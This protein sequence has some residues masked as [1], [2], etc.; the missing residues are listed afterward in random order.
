MCIRAL[1]HS[2][3]CAVVRLCMH[4]RITLYVRALVRLCMHNCTHLCSCTFMHLCSCT[5]VPA[6]LRNRRPLCSHALVLAQLHTIMQLC[7]HAFAQTQI[8]ESTA[9]S[10]R[11]RYEPCCC[12]HES[13]ASRKPVP[14][15]CASSR[16]P[17][18]ERSR[19]QS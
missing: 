7:V 11:H 17:V 8:M 14:G 1:A 6:L 10:R 5:F 18:H 16:C 9:Y 19:C 3:T 12:H 15:A 4:Y 2:C 13:R